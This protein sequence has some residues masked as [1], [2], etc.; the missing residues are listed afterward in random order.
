MTRFAV[1]L[2]P[3]LMA[4]FWVFGALAPAAAAPR[5]VP[6]GDPLRRVLLDA[7]RPEA[8][9]LLAPPVVFRVIEIAADRDRAFARLYATRP[10][11]GAIEMERTPVVTHEGWSIDMIDGPRFEVFFHRRAGIWQV[12]RWDMGATD[13]WWYGYDCANYAAFY[14][15]LGC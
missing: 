14:D 15:G 12:V 3:A 1:L 8:E 10:G 2:A 6:V 7:I 5:D 13:A 4:G 11:G 9:A